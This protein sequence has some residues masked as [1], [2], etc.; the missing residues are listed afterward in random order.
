L[1]SCL[2]TQPAALGWDSESGFLSRAQPPAHPMALG[3]G[4]K[5]ILYFL[6]GN[7]LSILPSPSKNSVEKEVVW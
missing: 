2:A 6:S 4:W 1:G 3:K 5:S 7:E